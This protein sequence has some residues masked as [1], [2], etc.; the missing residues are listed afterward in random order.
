MLRWLVNV[1]LLALPIAVT[2]GIL[3]GLQSQSDEPLFKNPAGDGGGR[4]GDNSLKQYFECNRTAGIHPPTDGQ[5]YT[6]KYY[7][8]CYNLL[9]GILL[10]GSMPAH[11]CR[12]LDGH[13]LC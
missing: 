9:G 3:I 8:L 10:S 7:E 1:G 6:C 5:G 4:K 13:S 11:R 12:L 2:L